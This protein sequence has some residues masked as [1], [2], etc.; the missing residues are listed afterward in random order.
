MCEKGGVYVAKRILH[1]IT[2]MWISVG[3]QPHEP[4]IKAAIAL[5]A[6][7]WILAGVT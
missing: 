4:Y 3:A 7:P 6:T 1:I 2:E 5:C